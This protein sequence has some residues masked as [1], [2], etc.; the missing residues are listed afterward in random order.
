MGIGFSFGLTRLFLGLGSVTNL[1]NHNP[2]GIW[3][4]F[5][6]ACGVA[7]AAGGF[8][9]RRPGGDLRPQEVPGAAA[10]GA[11]DRACWATCGW[12]SP[13]CFDLGRYWN[14]W[15]PLFNWQG[16]SVLF[17]VAMCVTF[18]LVILSVEMSPAILEGLEDRIAGRPLGAG[19]LRRLERPIYAAHVVGED[20]PAHLRRRRGGAVLHA[21]VLARHPDA[22]RTH[23]DERAVGHL[24]PAAAVPSVGLHGRLPDGYPGVH[25]RNHQLR[26]QG[27]DGAADPPGPRRPVVSRRLRGGEDRRPRWFV[28]TDPTSSTTPAP[29]SLW[30]S[31]S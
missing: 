17:E 20:R 1:D 27:G 7:L 21:P 29:R 11:A 12:P 16:N 28:T 5:D 15:R 6:V 18:Y 25:L 14:V 23:Q 3:I 10:A 9:H 26:P 19:L 31:R 13:C 4:A 2:W 8:H 30:W 24:H 22:D